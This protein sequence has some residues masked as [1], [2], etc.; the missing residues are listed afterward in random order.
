MYRYKGQVKGDKR[1]IRKFDASNPLEQSCYDHLN[2][3]KEAK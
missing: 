3:E 1:T 2:C